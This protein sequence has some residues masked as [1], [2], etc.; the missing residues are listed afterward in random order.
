[1]AQIS[2]K[3]AVRLAELALTSLLVA[4]LVHQLGELHVDQ[5]L[6]RFRLGLAFALV[7]CASSIE[8]DAILGQFLELRL[9]PPYLSKG[10]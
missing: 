8:A 4:A 7:L 3:Q 10:A 1:M 5:R 2:V 9:H 6:K